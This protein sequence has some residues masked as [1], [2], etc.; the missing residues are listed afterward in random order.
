MGNEEVPI[1]FFEY[2]RLVGEN[3][4]EPGVDRDSRNSN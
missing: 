3:E 2:P 1:R 4:I